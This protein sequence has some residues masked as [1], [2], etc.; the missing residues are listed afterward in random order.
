[1]SA[2]VVTEMVDSFD[3]VTRSYHVVLVHRVDYRPRFAA[4]VRGV[5]VFS[6]P[7]YAPGRT[8]KLQLCTPTYYRDQ[9][10]LTPGI[11]DRDDSTLTKDGS[12]WASS[13]MGGIAHAHLRFASSREPWL[14][15]AAHYRDARELGRLKHEFDVEYGYPATTRIEDPATFAVWLGVDFA[16]GLDKTAEVTL[17][18]IDQAAYARSHYTTD[19]W[20]GSGPVDTVVHVYHGPVHYED[21]SG[22]VETQEQWFDP[23]AGPKSW[24]I[25]RTSFER[26]SEYRFAVTTLGDPVQQKH[27]VSVSPELRAL[28]SKL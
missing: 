3:I 1:M 26:Q 9:E 27:Y 18:P 11:R 28:T 7:A 16:L 2:P 20:D 19:L 23:F 6:K 24:F 8:E 17:G 22:S 13:T 14:Y 25:K 4:P 12:V 10:D 21:G 5:A 15:C